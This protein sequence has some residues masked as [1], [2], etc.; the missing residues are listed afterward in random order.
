[1]CLSSSKNDHK[2]E[3]FEITPE[4]AEAGTRVIEDQCELYGSLALNIA[5]ETFRAM[6]EKS[7]QG[8]RPI[9]KPA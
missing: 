1:M 9:E 5:C 8:Y 6:I 2:P 4:M 7:P 3:D